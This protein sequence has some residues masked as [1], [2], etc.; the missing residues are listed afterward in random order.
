MVTVLCKGALLAVS[1]FSPV[2]RLA[3]G[4]PRRDERRAIMAY[5]LEQGVQFGAVLQAISRDSTLTSSSRLHF[6]GAIQLLCLLSAAGLPTC[7]CALGKVSRPSG[8]SKH[9]DHSHSSSSKC[10]CLRWDTFRGRMPLHQGSGT[11][12][13]LGVPACECVEWGGL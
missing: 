13:V 1:V 2:Q 7:S 12:T 3:H 9:L 10:L 6:S 8:W 4:I 5:V 11:R